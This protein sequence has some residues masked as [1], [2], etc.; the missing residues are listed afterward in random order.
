[1][2]LLIFR[3]ASVKQEMIELYWKE[4]TE[5]HQ[6][7]GIPLPS[8][9]MFG[10]GTKSMGDKLGNLV[11]SGLKT[12]TCSAFELFALDKEPLPELGQYD[13]ILNGDSEPIAIIKNTKIEMKKMNEVDEVFA[14]SEGEGDLSYEYWY[15]AHQGFF[16]EQLKRHNLKFSPEILLVCENF[17]VIDIRNKSK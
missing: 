16:T 9:W 7:K 5:Q 2:V 13:M 12:G 11:L 3:R 6:L 15:E 1:M 10:D 8:A 14:R 4:F 17:E